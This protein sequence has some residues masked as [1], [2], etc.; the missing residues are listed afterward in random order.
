MESL[1]R[2][3]GDFGVVGVTWELAWSSGD[4]L[5]ELGGWRRLFSSARFGLD[6]KLCGDHAER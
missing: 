4:F 5:G 1:A 2:R 6:S 3:C